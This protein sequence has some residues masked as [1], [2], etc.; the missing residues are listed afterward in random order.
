MVPPN[1]EEA[2]IVAEIQGLLA[3]LD[4]PAFHAMEDVTSSES[5]DSDD[6]GIEE[7]EFYSL[8]CFFLS[9]NLIYCVIMQLVVSLCIN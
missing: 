5:E 1:E 4:I 7:W 3:E 8:L 9:F 2:P 6:S